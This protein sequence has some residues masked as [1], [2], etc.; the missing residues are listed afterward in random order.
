MKFIAKKFNELNTN[1]LYEILKARAQIFIIEQNMHYQDLDDIDYESLHCFIIEDKK[2][3]GYLRAF[4]Q[5]SNTIKIGRV[6]TIK[7]GIGLGKELLNKSLETIKTNM[8]C[9]KITMA[10]QKHAVGFYKKW[11]FEVT[12]NDFLEENVVHVIM[13]KEL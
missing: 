1:E 2:I 12:S 8:P 7:H 9:K 11:G 13:E 4:Y 5:D 3:L 6:L 10:A